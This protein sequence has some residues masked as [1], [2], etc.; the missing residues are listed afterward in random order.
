[1]ERKEGTYEV[2]G[3]WGSD[4]ERF[5]ALRQSDRG[6]RTR[7]VF[8]STGGALYGDFVEPPNVENYPKDPESPYGIAKLSTEY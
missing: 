2:S 7:F 6:Q 3:L 5:E 1:M 8:S 4:G